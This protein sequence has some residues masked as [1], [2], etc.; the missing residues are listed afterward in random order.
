MPMQRLRKLKRRRMPTPVNPSVPQAL[1]QKHV[2]PV[3]KMFAG[4]ALGYFWAWG[5]TVQ[6]ATSEAWFLHLKGVVLAP[7]FTIIWQVTDFWSGFD[8]KYVIAYTWAWGIQVLMLVF[9]IGI[10]WPVRTPAG[11][12]RARLFKYGTLICIVLNSLADFFFS[13]SFG[14]WEQLAFVGITLMMSFFFG[15]LGLNLILSG[16]IEIFTTRSLRGSH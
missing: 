3:F 8:P 12:R 1:P 7:H 9:S 4:G 2:W 6:L 14:I 15:L 11:L 16:L 10:E 5:N 13:S